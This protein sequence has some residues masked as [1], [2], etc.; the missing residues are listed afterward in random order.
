M[1]IGRSILFFLSLSSFCFS[2]SSLIS[3]CCQTPNAT[4]IEKSY[5]WYDNLKEKGVA[6]TAS[7]YIEF[8][9]NPVGGKARGVGNAGCFTFT[10]GL[11]LEKLLHVP[12]LRFF[13]SEAY[14]SGYNL[15]ARKIDNQFEVTQLYGGETYRLV[16]LYLQETLFDGRLR[17]KA[18]RLT[19]GNDFLQSPLYCKYLNLA[20]CGNPIT[21]L[22]NTPFFDFPFAT[23]GGYLDFKPHESLLFK[24]AVYN[25]NIK[26]KENR[27]HG[28]NFTFTSKQGI[29]YI[30]EWVYLLN[31][32]SKD[33]GQPGN[34]KIGAYYISGKTPKFEGGN[35]HGNT[36]FYILL[37]QLL[38]RAKEGTTQ[39]LTS[40]L[41]LLFAPS[42][43][44]EFPLFVNG[45]LIYKGVFSQRPQDYL[46]FGTAYGLYSSELRNSQRKAS[47][48]T[49]GFETILELSY[50]YQWNKRFSIAP[51][52]QYVINPK[53]Y[54][55]IPNAFVIAVQLSLD[56]LGVPYQ[57]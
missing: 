4:A 31:Q 21:I 40:Y 43:R 53:G 2:E 39:G 37:D 7:Y 20:F 22:F 9:G 1:N 3:S 47:Q 28:A 51:D 34:Y 41:S 32:G 46:T 14:R 48:S 8:A 25:N 18:G 15:T 55:T 30:T 10:L 35:Q 29:Y 49:Q 27:Y 44:N 36:G 5:D 16:E 54:G 56:L 12:G 52:L 23:W 26:I 57:P 13:T 42:N 38:Y 24:F 50:W 33:T 11:D 19:E 45:G 6:M 17:V